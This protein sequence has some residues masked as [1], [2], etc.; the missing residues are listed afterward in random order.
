MANVWVLLLK[1]LPGQ[2]LL[3]FTMI[4]HTGS[5]KCALFLLCC[6]GTLL[7]TSTLPIQ[8]TPSRHLQSIIKELQYTAKTVLENYQKEEKG[9]TERSSYRL[10]CLTSDPKPPNSLNSSAILTYFQTIRPLSQNQTLIDEIIRQLEKLC[11]QDLPK[12]EVSVPERSF[13]RKRFIF[14]ILKQFSNCMDQV[15]GLWIPKSS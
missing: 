9:V 5:K 15:V 13:E 8:P 2:T 3:L 12:M 6:M 1:L 4:S 11:S 10:P 7:S 14:T